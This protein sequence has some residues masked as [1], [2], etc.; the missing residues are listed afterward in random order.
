[1]IINQI[2]TLNGTIPSIVPSQLQQ[3]NQNGSIVTDI[4]NIKLA[5]NGN[6]TFNDNFSGIFVSGTV[7][8]T[9]TSISHGLGSVPIGYIVVNQNSPAIIYS[10]GTTTQWSASIVYLSASTTTSATLWLIA[11]G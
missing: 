11:G 5:I 8:T 4:T 2:S 7:N 9:T 10:S 6:L 3:T 1:M